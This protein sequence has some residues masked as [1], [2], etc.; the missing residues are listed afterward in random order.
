MAS[1][2]YVRKK[3]GPHVDGDV[4]K[5]GTAAGVGEGQEQQQEPIALP[6]KVRLERAE[7]SVRK[8]VE[9]VVPSPKVQYCLL[10]NE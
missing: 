8:Q 10:G 9:G 5:E 7:I 6:R 2:L 3:G 4:G 1:M